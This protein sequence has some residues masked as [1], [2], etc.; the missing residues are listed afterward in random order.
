MPVSEETQSKLAAAQA[1]LDA[2]Q[3]EHDDAVKAET[4]ARS[5]EVVL[6]DFMRAVAA[7]LDNHPELRTL[8]AEFESVIQPPA[9]PPADT[10]APATKAE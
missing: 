9:P 6:L 1:A 4:P 2:A 7:K 5:P 8:L 10:A 3:K